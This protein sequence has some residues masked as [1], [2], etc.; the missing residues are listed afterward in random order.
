LR[1]ALGV[2]RTT[3]VALVDYL[4]QRGLAKRER[5]PSDR[6]A[7]NIKLTA[8][9]DALA[10]KATSLMTKAEQRMFAPLDAEE[11]RTLRR[12]STCLLGNPGPIAEV[13]R[14]RVLANT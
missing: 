4:E 13:H 12:L 6:R 5:S 1:N 3:V 14:S 10:K 7:Y 2:D 11:R 8:K 9:G